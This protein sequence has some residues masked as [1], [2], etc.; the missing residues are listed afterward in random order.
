MENKVLSKKKQKSFNDVNFK[1]FRKEKELLC[2]KLIYE[3]IFFQMVILLNIEEIQ[4]IE[5]D[6][7]FLKRDNKKMFIQ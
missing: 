1:N 7:I 5:E 2:P 3:I 6:F 4:M